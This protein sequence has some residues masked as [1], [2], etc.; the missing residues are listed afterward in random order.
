MNELYLENIELLIG[1]YVG[2]LVEYDH[3]PEIAPSYEEPYPNAESVEITAI[4]GSLDESLLGFVSDEEWGR[5]EA[6]CLADY[7]NKSG[8]DL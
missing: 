7:K 1:D 5:I 6:V 2:G 3:V 8:E 4:T